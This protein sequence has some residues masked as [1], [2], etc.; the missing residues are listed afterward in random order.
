MTIKQLKRVFTSEISHLYPQ[1]EVDSFFYLLAKEILSLNRVDIALKFNE[2][3]AI[4][5]K[6]HEA[7]NNLSE[8]KPI[9]YILGK[10][11]FYGLDF[12]VN[13]N[14]L[15]PRPETEELVDW[16]IKDY[17]NT[18]DL[19]ILDIG[20]G[21][22]CI[23]ISLAK[24]TNNFNITALDVSKKALEIAKY[25]T[26]NNTVEITFILDD[27]LSPKS[28]NYIKYD[29][30][31]SNPP[32]VRALEKEEINNNV[33]K[34]EPHL[35]LFVEDHNALVFYNAIANFAL[36]HLTNKGVLYFEINQYLG[37]ETVN[38]LINKGFKNVMLKK[39]IFNND[40]MI[41]A[42]HPNFE[43]DKL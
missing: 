25:N 24:N 16:I 39:D 17:K 33:L 27:I 26:Q 8:Q 29:I 1:T 36:K 13:N 23:A 2:E 11:E 32:Y 4:S 21:S 37:Q 41:K 34:N 19:K 30:I 43:F 9:Q 42:F 40:R 10:T 6:F 22:G 35:A 12:K 28:Q 18:K 20:T 38:L 5:Q 7:L 31:V 14:V 3:I 15:I